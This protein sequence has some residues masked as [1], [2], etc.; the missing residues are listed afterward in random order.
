MKSKEAALL[1]S[2]AQTAFERWAAHE[3]IDLDREEF[4]DTEQR[5]AAQAKL[6]QRLI[7]F[8]GEKMEEYV[9]VFRKF[10]CLQI[11][12]GVA[13]NTLK[14]DS[15]IRTMLHSNDN[16]WRQFYKVLKPGLFKDALTADDFKD[17][18]EANM[19][20]AYQIGWPEAA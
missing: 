6:N 18:M 2:L 1:A 4:E 17:Q 13:N 7:Y 10:L 3:Q 14:S 11:S 20:S 19:P 12:T 5:S 15:A 9:I 16:K 8:M